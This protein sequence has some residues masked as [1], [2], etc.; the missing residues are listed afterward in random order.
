MNKTPLISIIMP[1]YNADAFLAQALDS[2]LVQTYTDFELIAIDD[3]S[4]DDSMD[5]LKK[6]AGKDRRIA[7]IENGTNQG[8][9]ASLNRG[10]VQA[11][12]KYLARMD[13][14]DEMVDARL[15]EQIGFLAKH[16]EC[17]AVGSFMEEINECDE[18]IGRRRLPIK[19][20]KIY[21]MMMYAMGMQHPTIMFSRALTPT[22]FE[23]YRDIAYA[24]DLDMLFRLSSY[25][26]FA[27]IPK[28][29]YRYRI[30]Q[31]NESLSQVRH[32]FWAAAKVRI[33]TLLTRE[34]TPTFT[35]LMLFGVSWF[36]L[37]LPPYFSK[38]IYA[39]LRK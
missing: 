13:A 37:L 38:K 6:Y 26:T 2:V 35:G 17:V 24:E 23:W 16:P 9:A 39:E 19:H 34:Y 28:V 31:G 7:I 36:V 8:V 5:I 27:N 30:H 25:G 11:R 18:V 32:T 12:G 3:G 1:V 20:E 33:K 14:D 10:I 21:Q 4:S 22:N 29:L 15:S